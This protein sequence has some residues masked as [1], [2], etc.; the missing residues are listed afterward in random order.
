M[1]R[2]RVPKRKLYDPG[3]GDAH[4]HCGVCG[5]RFMGQERAEVVIKKTSRRTVVHVDP[6][7]NPRTM[8]L[9]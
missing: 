8:D 5:E 3:D 7:Y 2:P 4:S 6:C 1:A 9:A